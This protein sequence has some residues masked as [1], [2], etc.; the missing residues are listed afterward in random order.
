MAYVA[1]ARP[2]RVIVVDSDGEN[3]GSVYQAQGLACPNEVCWSP[4][5]KHLAIVLFDWIEK[6]G[7]R[8]RSIALGDD[9]NWRIA[10]IDRDGGNL[11]TVQLQDLSLMEIGAPDWR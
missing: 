2:D 11:R 7:T 10:I 9:N 6:N 3:A 8:V 4:D 5:G 1:S